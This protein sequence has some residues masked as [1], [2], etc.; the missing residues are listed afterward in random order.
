MF[1]ISQHF[2]GPKNLGLVGDIAGFLVSYITPRY[3]VSKP[4]RKFHHAFGISD[5]SGSSDFTFRIIILNSW[6]RIN[7]LRRNKHFSKKVSA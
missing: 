7:F 3:C 1:R 5:F 4:K 6:K 2:Y